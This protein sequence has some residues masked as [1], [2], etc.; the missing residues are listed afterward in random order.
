MLLGNRIVVGGEQG[1]F[2]AG[3]VTFGEVDGDESWNFTER[4]TD[5]RFA[6]ASRDAR[7]GDGIVVLRLNGGFG[8]DCLFYFARVFVFAADDDDRC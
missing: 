2:L 3:Q 6:T 1:F 8:R 7:H 4:R 5:A